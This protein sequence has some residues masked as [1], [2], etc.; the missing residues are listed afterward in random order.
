MSDLEKSRKYDC[1]NYHSGN[2][3]CLLVVCRLGNLAR[4]MK[5]PKTCMT[6][7]NL[8][9]WDEW[10]WKV[11]EIRLLK[12]PQGG[13]VLQLFSSTTGGILMQLILRCNSKTTVMFFYKGKKTVK[14][15]NWICWPFYLL[16]LLKSKC[17]QIGKCQ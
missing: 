8:N 16:K 17:Q 6:S 2:I 11:R 14:Y 7:L 10:F 3:H 9:Q 5:N 12:L 4:A 13:I 1:W 15:N